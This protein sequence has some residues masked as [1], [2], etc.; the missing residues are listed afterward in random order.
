MYRPWNMHTQL[1]YSGR[2]YDRKTVHYWYFVLKR[3]IRLARPSSLAI[4]QVIFQSY[5][6]YLKYSP[7][8]PAI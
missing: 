6:D 3:S 2:C 4:Y 7:H 8:E 1:P 5:S